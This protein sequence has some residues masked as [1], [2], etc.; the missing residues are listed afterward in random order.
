MAR[1]PKETR[2]EDRGVVVFVL[3]DTPSDWPLIAHTECFF[4]P[5]AV[6]LSRLLVWGLVL[7][8]INAT[9]N[10]ALSFRRVGLSR[11]CIFDF[12]HPSLS[13]DTALR[14]AVM[15]KPIELCLE[16]KIIWPSQLEAP[17]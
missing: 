9:A 16:R 3:W 5:I 7:I 11:W 17:S 15:D 10:A 13:G 6:D 4:V 2:I 12:H 14:Q 1:L 8:R